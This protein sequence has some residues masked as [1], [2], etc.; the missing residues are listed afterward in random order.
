MSEVVVSEDFL[1]MREQF[2]RDPLRRMTRDEL[3]AL[4]RLSMEGYETKKDVLSNS[5]TDQVFYL[6]CYQA[7]KTALGLAW[8]LRSD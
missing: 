4:L 2:L 1:T 5:V 8:R 3:L 7:M 6:G